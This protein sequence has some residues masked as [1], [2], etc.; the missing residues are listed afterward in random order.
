MERREP[1]LPPPEASPGGGEPPEHVPP[2]GFVDYWDW[3]RIR[4]DRGGVRTGR[5]APWL[6][7][8]ART[9][10]PREILRRAVVAAFR[11][12]TGNASAESQALADLAVTGRAAFT[13]F[14]ASPPRDEELFNAVRPELGTIAPAALQDA[15]RRVLDRAY[16]VAWALRGSPAQ[17]RRLRPALGWIALSSEDDPPHAPTNLPA[18]ADHMGE[19]TMRIGRS[20]QEVTLRATITLPT[21]PATEPLP[22]ISRRAVPAPTA[23]ADALLDRAAAGYDELFL[24]IHGLGSRAEESGTFKRALIEL[25]AARGRRYAV[26]SVDMP[27]MG[28]SSRIDLDDLVAR[29]ARGFHGFALPDGVGSNFPLLGLYRDTLVELCNL[30]VGGVQYVMGGSLGGN[31]T[32]WLAAEPMFTDL[33]PPGIEPA[34]VVSFLS[35]SPGSIWESYERSRDI[36]EGD[37]THMDV[38]KN[39]A[40]KRSLERMGER[41]NEGRRW[42][43]FEKMQR[44][45]DFL[46]IH[47]LGAWGYPPTKSGLLLQAELYGEQYR[48]TFWAAAY[49]QVTFSHQEPLT[50]SRR[51][52]FQTIRKPLFLAVGARDVGEA[53]VADIYNEAIKVSDRF[54]DIPGRRRLMRETGHSIS[55][56]RPRHLAEQLVDFLAGDQSWRHRWRHVSQIEG[57]P[58]LADVNCDAGAAVPTAFGV[59]LVT[60]GDVDRDGQAELIV[61]PDLNGTGGNDLW[62]MKFDRSRRTWSHLS[63]I[64]GHPFLADVNC[65]DGA[66][67]PT[68]FGVKS[69]IAADVDGDG[70]AELIVTPDATGTAGNDLWVMKYDRSRR[71][72]S[73]LSPLPGHSFLADVNCDDGVATPTRFGV[74]SVTAADVDGDGQAELI[75]TPDT[76]GTAGNDLWVMKYDRSRRTWSHL[77]PIPGHPFLADVNCDAGASTPTGFGVK[78]VLAADVDGDGRAELIV[79]PDITG[80]AGNDLWVMKYDR[81]RRTWSHLSPIPGH[82]FL[83]DVN[84]DDGTTPTRF[85][86]KSVTVGDVNGDGQAEL[87]VAP[88]TT[89]TAG[90]DLWVMAF[91]RERRVWRHLSPIPGHPFLADVNCDFGAARPTPFGVKAVVSADINGDRKAEVIVAPDIT[92]TAGNDL[93]VMR[94]ED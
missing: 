33:A 27:G 21:A 43:F 3:S 38:G 62:V 46:G 52:P 9:R 32:L 20:A 91:D 66:A 6:R 41:E 70:Q 22:D 61:A 2:A 1:Y 24:F 30:T 86:I 18:T 53:G 72:W 12:V 37:G 16:T 82:P 89:G 39:G 55:D 36:P 56:E 25:G 71:R 64:P 11:P 63:P 51:W 80:T 74:K 94:P 81:S 50:P 42:E 19:L 84:C 93:W 49:E 5:L 67:I 48:R 88:D 69:V 58:F 60:T 4:D 79:A 59:K 45:E 47:I 83:A 35:W 90:N 31:M 77:S 57:H 23:F 15:V 28:Y 26:L 40:K 78:S 44:G 68:R 7:E 75:V 34:S 10:N 17:R 54:P 85:G 8:A 29:R 87:I 13:R 73:H 14:R 76:N 92:G 65:D